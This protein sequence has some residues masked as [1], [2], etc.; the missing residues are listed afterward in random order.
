MPA[1]VLAERVSML[2]ESLPPVRPRLA[3]LLVGLMMWLLPALAAANHLAQRSDGVAIQGY[4]TV[5]YFTEG[6]PM[7]GQPEFEDVWAGS[8]WCS[9]SGGAG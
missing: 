1:E 2:G 9:A 5:A 4:D 8:R 6:S 7:Q 3:A